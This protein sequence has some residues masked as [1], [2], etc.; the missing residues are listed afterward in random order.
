MGD[1]L[2]GYPLVF[3][4]SLGACQPLVAVRTAPFDVC[5]AARG[6]TTIIALMVAFLCTDWP[7]EVLALGAAGLLLV[8]RKLTSRDMLALVDW[9]LL[10]LFAALF[11][12]KHALVD[13]GSLT[14]MQRGLAAI[15][16]DAGR[17]AWLFALAAL[18]SNLVSNVPAVMLLLPTARGPLAGPVLALASTLAGNFILVGSIA[19]LIVVD[20]AARLQVVIGW[21][22][23]ARVG[24]PITLCTLAAAAAWLWL[25]H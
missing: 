10:V 21:R 1:R 4:L 2:G 12:V 8:S 7:R 14:D 17:P 25:R 9:P 3:C 13:S 11:V 22:E 24:I 23:H 18:L 15:G 6:V 19:N 16:V 20:Q 5:Q